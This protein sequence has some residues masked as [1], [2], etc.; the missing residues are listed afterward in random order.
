[1]EET[2]HFDKKNIFSDK[3]IITIFVKR[4]FCLIRKYKHLS[5]SNAEIFTLPLNGLQSDERTYE[6]YLLIEKGRK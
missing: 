4:C 5:L 2:N 6:T 3:D 1:M